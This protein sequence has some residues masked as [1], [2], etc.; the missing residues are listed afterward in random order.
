[1]LLFQM[2]GSEYGIDSMT[3]T[4][5]VDLSCLESGVLAVDLLRNEFF[6]GT[7]WVP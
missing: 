2:A 4:S 6:L 7:L 3:L 5:H 1:M